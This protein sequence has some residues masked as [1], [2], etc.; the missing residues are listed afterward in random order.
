MKIYRSFSFLLLKN[1]SITASKNQS[2]PCTKDETSSTFEIK[3]ETF[4]H[5]HCSSN[6]KRHESFTFNDEL[7]CPL[8]SQ[9]LSPI[10]EE[11]SPLEEFAKRNIILNKSRSL[12]VT[13]RRQS[14]H[15]G[16]YG[17]EIDED[18]SRNIFISSIIDSVYCPQ[19]RVGDQLIGINFN[20]SLKTLEQYHLFLNNLWH[21]PIDFLTINI[22]RSTSMNSN[23]TGKL[24]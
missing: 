12:T 13:V 20:C 2:D 23:R 1:S 17:F 18:L 22:R 5:E 10:S 7:F 24:S 4:S 8:L 9:S 21:R 19:L 6:R 11:S 16:H 3:T 15:I 14:N